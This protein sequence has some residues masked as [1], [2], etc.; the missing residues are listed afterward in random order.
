M[1]FA[2]L[3]PLYPEKRV[4]L[5]AQEKSSLFS[6]ESVSQ[7]FQKTIQDI[8]KRTF[9]WT[10]LVVSFL[11]I[12]FSVAL[13]AAFVEYRLSLPKKTPRVA[14][15]LQKELME[16]SHDTSVPSIRFA[17]LSSFLRAFLGELS[18]QN[19]EGHDVQSLVQ[20]LQNMNFFSE[21]E[22]SELSRV[23]EQLEAY[24]FSNMQ[25]MDAREVEDAWTNLM[26]SRLHSI[27][28]RYLQNPP[29]RPHPD[30]EDLA[31]LSK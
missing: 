18:C 28:L 13:G 4:A 3:S 15:D 24:E 21:E 20:L 1:E 22:Q 10:S 25:E 31:L 14:R 9:A 30:H 8:Q 27:L 23:L 26:T 17:K 7:E 16:L 11:V 12:G 6:K 5:S 29:P 19:L 2:P